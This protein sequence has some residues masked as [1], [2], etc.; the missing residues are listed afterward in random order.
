MESRGEGNVTMFKVVFKILPQGLRY[1]ERSQ[2][3]PK[4]KRKLREKEE[5]SALD[6]CKGI[7]FFQI[8][9]LILGKLKN[10]YFLL[11]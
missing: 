6:S 10:Y 7:F 4:E 5:P 8:S 3:A 1:W 9:L 2:D 11:F